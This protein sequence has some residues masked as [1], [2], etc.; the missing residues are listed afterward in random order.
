M[1]E[2]QLCSLKKNEN[3]QLQS[4]FCGDFFQF[5][6]TRT[7]THTHPHNNEGGNKLRET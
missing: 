5:C 2:I 4:G 6:D 3:V 1:T 7:H